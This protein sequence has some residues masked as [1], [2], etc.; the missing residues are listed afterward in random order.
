M[1][2]RGEEFASQPRRSAVW[3]TAQ[4]TA[5]QLFCYV[6]MATMA[7]PLVFICVPREISATN[8]LVA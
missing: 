6:R 2:R 4:H 1:Y 7:S 3:M 5:R 8:L